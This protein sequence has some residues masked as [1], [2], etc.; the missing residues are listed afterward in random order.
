MPPVAS[1]AHIVS[2]VEMN[3]YIGHYGDIVFSARYTHQELLSRGVTKHLSDDV[4]VLA[5]VT[6]VLE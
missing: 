1:S 3:E 2:A 6:S 5:F 4:I